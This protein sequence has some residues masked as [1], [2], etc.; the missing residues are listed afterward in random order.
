MRRKNRE[1]N[2]FSMSALDLFCSAMGA[3]LLLAL[4]ALPY[5]L[6][7]ERVCE[8]CPAR[9]PMPSGVPQPACPDGLSASPAP[10]CP[11]VAE[12]ALKDKLIVA[13]VTW[14]QATDVDL[15]VIT[16]DGHFSYQTREIAGRPGEMFLDDLGGNAGPRRELWLSKDPTPGR[17]QFCVHWYSPVGF[18]A[19]PVSGTV[20]K[21]SGSIAV[22]ATLAQPRSC[23]C[24]VSFDLGGDYTPSN[25]STT[26]RTC[27]F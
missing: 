15:H 8:V 6:R 4:I 1:L 2:I 19:L 13:A 3:F 17:Y 14:N 23:V 22:S 10:A 5:Y 7:E 27:N 16:P 18:G 26:P 9:A 21:P 12:P 25:V 20:Y 24:P 11:P